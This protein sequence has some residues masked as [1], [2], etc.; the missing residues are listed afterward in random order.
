MQ[1][2]HWQKVENCMTLMHAMLQIVT[3]D[4]VVAG[5]CSPSVDQFYAGLICM[6]KIFKR[7]RKSAWLRCENWKL[8]VMPHVTTCTLL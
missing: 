1:T 2:S 8:R 5:L 4:A 6:H 7:G 3:R